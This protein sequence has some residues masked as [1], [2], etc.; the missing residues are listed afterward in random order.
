MIDQVNMTSASH[1]GLEANVYAIRM[2]LTGLG[3]ERPLSR[4]MGAALEAQG[5]QMLIGRDVLASAILIYNGE[6]GDFTIGF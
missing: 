1:A 4:V 6:T 3:F 2:E 5:I